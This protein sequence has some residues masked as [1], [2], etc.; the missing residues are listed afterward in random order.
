M[1]F[2]HRIAAVPVSKVELNLSCTNL[3]DKDVTSKSDPCA[4]LFMQDSGK[5]YEVSLLVLL[6]WDW[7][8]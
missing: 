8:T 4:V 1:A 5:W 6:L 7:L 2:A 3:L